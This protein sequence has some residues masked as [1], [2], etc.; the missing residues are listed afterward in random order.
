[1]ELWS[2]SESTFANITCSAGFSMDGQ[3]ALQCRSDG[4]WDF[5]TP[6]C[7]KNFV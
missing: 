4:T 6:S 1:M 7:G 2:N 5:D 3:S